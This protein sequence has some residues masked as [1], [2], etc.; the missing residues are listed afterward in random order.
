MM[1][2]TLRSFFLNSGTMV[3][4]VMSIPQAIPPL[5]NEVTPGWVAVFLFGAWCALWWARE[6]GRLPGQRS[7]EQ[8]EE[9]FRRVDRDRLEKLYYL[10]AQRDDEGI[11]RFLKFAQEARY[12]WKTQERMLKVLQSIES[13]LKKQNSRNDKN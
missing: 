13:E 2:E 3:A 7:T 9:S 12:S 5:A 8:I 11:E 4:A 1:L 6:A 10:L